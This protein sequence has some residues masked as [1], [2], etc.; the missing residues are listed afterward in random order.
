MINR[1]VCL[2][3]KAYIFIHDEE[4][5]LYN[6]EYYRNISYSFITSNFPNLKIVYI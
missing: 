4:I 2:I 5:Y 1:K 6:F 3:T